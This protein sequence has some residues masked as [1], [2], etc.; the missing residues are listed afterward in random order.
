MNDRFIMHL[1]I[2]ELR[3]LIEEV[4][5]GAIES[6]AK[7]LPGVPVGDEDELWTREQVIKYFGICFP[8]LHAW[9][10]KG[11]LPQALKFGRRR[12]FK[13]VDILELSA[14]KKT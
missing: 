12:Y 5:L 7:V 3:Q 11:Y 6:K 14:K 9:I 10:R 8:T 1:T 2:E 13:K 4:V